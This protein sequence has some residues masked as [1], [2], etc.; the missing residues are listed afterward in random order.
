MTDFLGFLILFALTFA[1]TFAAIRSSY[2]NGVAD[3]FDACKRPDDLLWNVN[4]VNKILRSTGRVKDLCPHKDD[5]E[6]CPVCC[7]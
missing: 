7:H 4:G 6:Q 5:W 3:G 1:C 2:K